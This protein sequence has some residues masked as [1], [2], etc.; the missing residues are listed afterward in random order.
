MNASASVIREEIEITPQPEAPACAVID[1]Q[2]RHDL[3]AQAAYFR[4]QHRGFMRGH[5]QQDWLAAEME[6]DNAL[7]IGAKS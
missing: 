3:I 4:A 7:C 1:P 2:T 5:E 6:V